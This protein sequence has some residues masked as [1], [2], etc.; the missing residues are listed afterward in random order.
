[1]FNSA[2]GREEH[3]KQISLAC[4]VSA[5]SVSTTLGLP[6]FMTCM[7]SQSTL[8]RLQVAL[9]GNC[10]KVGPGFHALPRST[11]LRFRFLGSLQRHRIGW[12][13]VLCPSQVREVQATRCLV[14][15]LSPGAVH[16][17]TSAVPAA[18]FPECTLGALS[19]VCHVSPLG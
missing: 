12:A 11:L 14:S 15:A 2:A 3:C 13:C 1:M 4:V 16:L 10:P 17:I 18:R 19:Q 9:Q 8:L 7:L 5:R 6:P